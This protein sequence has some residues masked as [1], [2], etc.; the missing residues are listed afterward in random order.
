VAVFTDQWGP[1]LRTLIAQSGSYAEVVVA[2]GVVT[3]V[4][5]AITTTPVPD[6]GLVIVGQGT[7]AAALA[8]AKAGDPAKLDFALKSDSAAKLRTALGSG[9]VLVRNGQAIDFPPSTGNDAPKPRTAIGWVKGGGRLLLVTVDGGANFATGLSFDDTAALMARLGAYEAFMLD[10]GGSSDLVARLPGD[11]GTSVINTP[12]DGVERPIPNGVGLFAAQGSGTLQGLDVRPAADRVFPGLTLDVAA[13]GYD[14]TYAPVALGDRRVDWDAGRLGRVD[15]GVLRADRSGSGE[16]TATAGRARGRADLRVLGPLTRLKFS[17]PGL[18]LDAGGSGRV[19]LTGYDAEGFDAPLAPRDTDL[20]YDSSVVKVEGQADGSLLVTGLATA[21]GTGTV[22][23]AR[24][25][26]TTVR[27]PIAVGLARTPMAGFEPSETWG[28]STAKAT[29]SVG[30]VSA[31]GRPGAAAGSQALRLTY[32]FTGTSGTSAAYAVA[33]P[34]ALTLPPATRRLGLWVNG[35][36]KRHWLRATLRSQ[37]TTNV[38]FTFATVVDWTGW[39]WV[40]GTLPAGFSEPITLTNIYV[41][42][43]SNLAK[44]AGQLDFDDL[45]ALVGQNVSADEPLTPD[46]FVL[47][48]ENVGRGRWTFALMSDLH[49][50]A[51]GGPDSFPARQAVKA[52]AQAVAAKPDFLVVNGDFV[53][54]N[55]PADFA[56][57]DDLLKAGVPP[58]IPVYWTPGNHESGATATGTLDTFTQVTGRPTHQV[59]DHKGTRFILLNTTLGGLRASDWPQVPELRQDLAQAA[60]DRRV[61]SVA[62]LFHHPLHDPSGAGSSQFSDQLEADLVE[63]WLANFREDSGKPVALFTGHAH[64]AAAGR[65]DGVLEVTTPPV[66]KTP[67]SSPD[68]GGFFGWMLV[69]TDPT[70]HEIKPGRPNPDTLT[71][72]TARVNPVIDTIA[73]SAPAQLTTGKPTPVSATATTAGVGLTFPLRYPASV[74]WTGDKGLATVNSAAEVTAATHRK[75][76]TAVLNLADNTLTGVH[77]GKITLT[78][79]SADRS[80]T[81]SVTVT[82]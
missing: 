17:V 68:K 73:L 33:K 3:A 10:G 6:G 34:A 82:R 8:A 54:T 58:S 64:T 57:A 5:G 20:S 75:D 36:G 16:L 25:H 30:S 41:V 79:S 22:I 1:G 76:V 59:F 44:D 27:L 31:E 24:V 62:V 80:A 63:K 48:Q 39:K 42:E 51:A 28:V 56:F 72:M 4:N 81:A 69:G 40:E 15:G 29:A 70:P 2:G 43:T 14:E 46:P 18:T 32:D 19:R 38:P 55:T 23:T 71:W 60:K 9:D 47:Q 52:L 67:Y 77:P 50:S 53:D 65:A 37:G 66:G 74:T 13:A 26:G 12:S 45:T 7:A 21:D 49:V 78:V 35:D 61:A 11:S